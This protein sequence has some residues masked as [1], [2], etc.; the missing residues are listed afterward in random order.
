MTLTRLRLLKIMIGGFDSAMTIKLDWLTSNA[1]EME[2]A[3]RYWAMNDDGD[4]LE[5]VND[6][7]PFRHITQSGTLAAYVRQLCKAFDENLVCRHCNGCMEVKSRSS[8]KKYLQTSPRPCPDCE[9]IHAEQERL[10][11]EAAAVEL[12]RQLTAYIETLPSGPIDYLAMSDSEV[13]LLRAL[14]LA[15]SPRLTRDAFMLSDC[16]ALA[17]AYTDQLVLRLIAAGILLEDPP[18]AMPGTYCLHNGKLAA[19]SRYIAYSLAADEQ[20]GRG[21]EAMQ[22]L[23]N[24]K[25]QDANGLFDL[26]LDVAC[27]D[28]MRYLHDKCQAFDHD[29]DEAQLEEIK[30]T[31]RSALKTHSVS[32]IWFVIWKNVKDAASLARLVYYSA[33]RAT[34]TIPGK[35]RR[36]LEKV[37]KEGTEL[38]MWERPDQQPAGTL[39]MMF[40]ELFGVDEDTPG[41]KVHARLLQLSP[42]ESFAGAEFAQPEQVRK[43]LCDAMINDTGPQ[44]LQQFAELVREGHD[45]GYAIMMMLGGESGASA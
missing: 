7:V 33:T 16:T 23:A 12:D 32:Q 34:A 26:W 43:L 18:N 45:T 44:M 8:A 25:Y 21:E 38:R 24:R 22:V 28:A 39:A 9:A 19:H 27:A 2:L 17:P 3:K 36:T 20:L 41:V 6:L 40:N 42:K 35:I 10:E 15:L 29:L 14:D 11:R 37:E 1:E 30:S 4:F 5:K 31:L 13:L